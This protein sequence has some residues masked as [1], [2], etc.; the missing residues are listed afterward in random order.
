MALGNDDEGRVGRLSG[1]GRR[2]AGW[3]RHWKMIRRV[4]WEVGM[5]IQVGGLE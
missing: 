4:E 2:M 3:F 1:V 5:V